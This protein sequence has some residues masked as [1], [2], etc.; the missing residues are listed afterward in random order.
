[1]GC[2]SGGTSRNDQLYQEGLFKR[3]GGWVLL[4]QKDVLTYPIK[5]A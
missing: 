3:E 2:V 1:M 5:P 4:D